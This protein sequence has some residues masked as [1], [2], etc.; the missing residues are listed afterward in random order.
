MAEAEQFALDRAAGLEV[1][2]KSRRRA[3]TD[4]YFLARVDLWL[5]LLSRGSLKLVD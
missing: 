3:G 5:D 1:A 4:S 2:E